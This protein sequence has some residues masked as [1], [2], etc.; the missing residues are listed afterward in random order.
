MEK[1]K[2]ASHIVIPAA[3]NGKHTLTCVLSIAGQEKQVIKIDLPDA[4]FDQGQVIDLF[5]NLTWYLE[6][7]HHAD[8]WKEFFGNGRIFEYSTSLLTALVDNA[9]GKL[10]PTSPVPP[11]TRQLVCNLVNNILSQDAQSFYGA[12]H[13]WEGSPF[14][15]VQKHV[16]TPDSSDEKCGHGHSE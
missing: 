7:L 10:Y 11:E 6:D 1:C 13:G 4:K 14:L 15:S 9:F 12:L 3:E 8:F 16:T 2:T 5:L